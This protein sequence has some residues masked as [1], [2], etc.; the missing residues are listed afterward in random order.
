MRII[1]IVLHIS[2]QQDDPHLVTTRTFAPNEWLP[3]ST[4]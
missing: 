3:V 4:D 1:G 2:G